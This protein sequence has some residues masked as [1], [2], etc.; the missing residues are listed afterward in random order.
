LAV[1]GEKTSAFLAL[2]LLLPDCRYQVMPFDEILNAVVEEK[3]EVGLLIHEGQL[4]FADFGLLKVLDLGAWWK[5]ETDLPLPLAGNV[6]R[7]DLGIDTTKMISQLISD[8]IRYALVHRD[9]ALDYALQFGHGLDRSQGDRFVEMYVNNRTLDFG[10]D[11][12]RAI[13]L[14]LDRGYQAGILPRQIQVDFL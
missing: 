11:G 10:E 13:E 12:R 1:P 6:V 4:S 5:R 14:F 7:R 9:A 8:S 3:V 2:R